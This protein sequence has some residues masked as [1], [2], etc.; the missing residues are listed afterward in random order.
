MSPHLCRDKFAQ[1]FRMV[2]WISAVMG[3][4]TYRNFR[5]CGDNIGVPQH[6][7][8]EAEIRIFRAQE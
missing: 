2:G 7:K 1:R 3:S 8:Q 6:G 4:L 5:N